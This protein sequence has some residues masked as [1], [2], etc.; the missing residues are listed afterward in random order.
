MPEDILP[1][2]NLTPETETNPVQDKKEDK[3]LDTTE[4]IVPSYSG[5]ENVN[6]YR[7]MRA[8]Q[9][10]A[11]TLTG[12]TGVGDSKLDFSRKHGGNPT[13]EQAI[14]IDEQRGRR[15]STGDKWANGLAKFV[16]KTSTNLMGG[17]V[18]AV[19]GAASALIIH[20]RTH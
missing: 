3:E 11:P 19:Y 14:D 6:R 9:E 20:L 7:G 17:T 12:S 13:I 8:S 2:Y 18:G 16:G 15:Q 4:A 5:F 1:Q 10:V